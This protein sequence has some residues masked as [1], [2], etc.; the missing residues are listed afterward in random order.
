MPKR[1]IDD[2][3]AVNKFDEHTNDYN[4]SKLGTSLQLSD[5]N[6]GVEF[7]NSKSC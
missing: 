2:L 3:H 5:N 7:N 1:T 4:D 6:T